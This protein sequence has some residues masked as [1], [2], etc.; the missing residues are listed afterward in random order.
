MK[1]IIQ[2]CVCLSLPLQRET[3]VKECPAPWSSD[4]GE[5]NLG[6][7]FILLITELSAPLA[8]ASTLG[9]GEGVH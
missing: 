6:S 7:Y 3:Q 2:R 9:V 4:S 5:V 8:E 1:A